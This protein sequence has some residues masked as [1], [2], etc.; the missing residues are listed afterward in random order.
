MRALS[1]SCL[2]FSAATAWRRVLLWLA[3]AGLATLLLACAGVTGG[4]RVVTVSEAQLAQRITEQFPLR[5]RYLELF[6]LTLSS[7][8]VRLIPAENRLGTRVDYAMGDFWGS[9]RRFDGA[10]TLS[11]GLRF[12]PTDNSVRMTDVKVE[13]FDVSR[14]SGPM[15]SQAQRL[16]AL[17]A[18]HLLNDFSLHRFKPEELQTA[19]QRGYRPGSLRVVESGLQLE[20][21]PNPN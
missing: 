14:L 21:L 6:D 12:E 15:A 1:L 13:A 19:Q 9:S 10:L 5:R 18:E 7:P 8:R 20:L 17:V 3:A 11:Y 4:P 2:S 16:G